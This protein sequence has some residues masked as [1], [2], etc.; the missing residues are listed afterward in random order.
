MVRTQQAQTGWNF[1]IDLSKA[2]NFYQPL[3][4]SRETPTISA[5]PTSYLSNKIQYVQIAD[6]LSHPNPVT[7]GVQQGSV[8]GPLLFLIYK[9]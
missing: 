7:A 9:I 4:S 5:D 2:F 8:L 6:K 1:F 3:N